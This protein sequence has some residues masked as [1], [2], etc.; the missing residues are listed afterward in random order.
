MNPSVLI[1]NALVVNEGLIERLD[2]LVVADYIEEIA[3]SIS[4]KSPHTRVIDADG[5]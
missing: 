1:K 3:P 2:V 4:A 5:L